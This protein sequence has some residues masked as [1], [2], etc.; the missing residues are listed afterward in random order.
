M[1]MT[2]V[3]ECENS[4][5]VVCV[6]IL[7][8]CQRSTKR[9]TGRRLKSIKMNTRNFRLQARAQCLQYRTRSHNRPHQFVKR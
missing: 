2:A 3:Y 9:N 8:N 5:S 4:V 6:F 7:A 1:K